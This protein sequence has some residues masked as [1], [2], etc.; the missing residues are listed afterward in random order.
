MT[1]TDIVEVSKAKSKIFI[2][3]EAV[4]VL[5][6]SEIRNMNIR[7]DE[8]LSQEDFCHI[9]EELLVKRAR[10]R[11]LNLLKGRDYTKHQLTM[12]LKQGFYPQTVIDN[13]IEYVTSYGYIDDVRYAQSYIKY[14]KDTKSKKQIEN[15]L[16]KKGVSKLDIESAYTQCIEKN[17]LMD[18]DALIQNLLRKKHYKRGVSTPEEQ[19]KIIAFLYRKGFSLDTIYKVVGAVE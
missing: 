3:H 2:D 15:D 9:M 8:S 4:F 16:Q 12:K 10:L 7:K 11:C 5:Y 19:R 17:I 14:A 6:K 13:A 18:E 1:V